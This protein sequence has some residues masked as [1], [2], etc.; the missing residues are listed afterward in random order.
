MGQ[1][2][3]A[4][5]FTPKVTGTWVKYDHFSVNKAKNLTIFH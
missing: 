3:A 2:A 1:Q 5:Q 4:L